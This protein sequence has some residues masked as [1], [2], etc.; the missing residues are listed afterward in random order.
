M[1]LNNIGTDSKEAVSL[2]VKQF[3][4][5]KECGPTPHYDIDHVSVL[6][7]FTLFTTNKIKKEP[8]PV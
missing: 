1:E 2:T 4:L 3:P 5:L 8:Q 7:E 6:K